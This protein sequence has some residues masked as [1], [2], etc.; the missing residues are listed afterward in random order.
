MQKF[1]I[2]LALPVIFTACGKKQNANISSSELK[3]ATDT[4][5]YA[6]A[7]DVA[8]RLK[9]MDI[10]EL[11]LD[12][13]YT[14]FNQV[15]GD[16]DTVPLIDKNSIEKVLETYFMQKQM[17]KAEGMKKQGDAFL[18]ENKSKEGVNVLPSGLQYKV[19]KAAIGAEEKIGNKQKVLV[20]YT[21][22]LID[23]KVFD[24]TEGSEPAEINVNEVIPGWTEAL[25]LMPIGSTWEI[26]LPADLAYGSSRGPGNALPPYS[27]LI[28][29]IELIKAI[30]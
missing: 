4:M 26:Y 25:K 2:L 13:V 16:A 17:E 24:S 29:K 11:N 5:S 1:M 28:F 14:A 6:L 3:T 7:Y 30:D 20:N 23:G 10:Q 8:T 19:I 27:V 9:G 12:A 18:N 22:R 21:G 15:F